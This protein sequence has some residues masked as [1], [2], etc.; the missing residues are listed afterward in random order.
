MASTIERSLDEVSDDETTP[1]GR[2]SS[3][4]GEAGFVASDHLVS[5]LQKV[6]VDLIELHLQ[7]KQAHWN[8]VGAGFRSIHLHLDDIVDEAR[9]F[10]DTIAERLRAFHVTPDGRSDTVAA[11]TTLHVYPAGEQSVADTA[12]LITRRLERVVRTLRTV[13]D[14]VDAEDPTST[15]L[16]HTIIE[17]LEKHAWMIGAEIRTP[18]PRT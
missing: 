6:V 1:G 13:H 14:S 15:D 16:L 11:T 9:E 4:N 5:S 7:A 10:S 12:D 17:A 8:V 3:E 2:T 18:T